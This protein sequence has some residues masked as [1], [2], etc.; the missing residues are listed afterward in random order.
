MPIVTTNQPVKPVQPVQKVNIPYEQP[1]QLT[2]I[3]KPVVQNTEQG[4]ELVM[5]TAQQSALDAQNKPNET[6]GLVQQ[7]VQNLIKNPVG[8]DTK[9]YKQNQLEQFDRN[10]A[11]SMKAFQQ[12]IADV[13]NTGVNAE[14]AYNFAMQGAQ[15][16][17]DLENKLAME[18]AEKERSAML[19]A[20]TAG[21]DVSKT[22]SGLDE[23]AFN[24]LL[25]TRSQYEGERSQTQGFQDNV[26]LTNLGFD[27]ATQLAAQQNGFDLNKLNTQYGQDMAKMI[28]QNDWQGAQNSLARETQIAMQSNDINAQ[29]AVQDK[30]FA[31]EMQKAKATQDWQGGQNA[32]DRAA[33][34]A[35]QN[36]DIQ[37]QKDIQDKQNAFDM[38]KL[39]KTQDWQ[40][41]QNKIE[42]DL[43]L[44]MQANDITATASNI[45]KQI[46]LDKWKQENGQTFT[47]DQAA[48]NRTLETA[49]ATMKISADIFDKALDRELT[50]EV[51][52]G[53]L[54]I[55]EKQLAQT[56]V[57]FADE[58]EFKKFA[59]QSGV[60]E[61][62]AQR[63]WQS[64]ESAFD[65][66]GA[67][68]LKIM[69]IESQTN[70]MNLKAQIDKGMLLTQQDFQ[71]AQNNID[72]K[73][74]LAMQSNDVAAQ[75]ELTLLKGQIDEQAQTAQ[76][77]F[78]DSQ[79]IATQTWQTGEAV[80]SEGAQKAAQYFEWQQKNL[81]QS[82]DIAGQVAL[83]SLKNKFNLNMQTNSMNHEEKMAYLENQFAEA[84]ANNDVNRQKDILSFTYNQDIKKMATEY[85]I[86]T[87]KMQ[88]QGQIQAAL[89]QGDYEHAEAMQKAL[90]TQQISENA[91]DRS[92]QQAQ[93][94]LQA[95]GINLQEVE[96]QYN[97]LEKLVQAG[98]IDKS[99]LTDFVSKVTSSSG[100]TLKAPDPL[101]AQKEAD[102]E[103]KA[104]QVEYARTHPGSID[105]NGNMTAD[106][107]SDFN[108]FVN[109]T[110]YGENPAGTEEAVSEKATN[111]LNDKDAYA[112]LLY[113][114][115][116]KEWSPETSY[117]SGGF[118]GAD[119][120]RFVNAPTNGSIFK[121][122]GK[123]YQV[124][125]DTQMDTKG[126]DSD[127]FTVKDLNDGTTRRIAITGNH[128]GQLSVTG[129]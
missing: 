25:N 95:K 45:Q 15:G 120:R 7:G 22:Q 16:R 50:K 129:F 53:R 13:Q 91:K 107:L 43:K 18:Q 10:R 24:R 36:N 52:S 6:M 122:N 57:Q 60:N 30:Q 12:S 126:E 38:E 17:S 79:R 27:H 75:K 123:A 90:F 59:L 23:T 100:V 62:A 98:N 58:I 78:V 119:K 20:L 40:S 83:E 115:T 42:N 101:E 44:S 113:D 39:N 93:V 111:A 116:V 117:D 77:N 46:D 99:V 125:S 69:E 55:Q 128:N 67:K 61:A 34:I 70:L 66:S 73:L 81:A 96:Q 47:A 8:Y 28:A 76:Q 110:M 104:L 84:K 3:S 4:N 65:R 68:D 56:A 114:P 35:K 97:Q 64:S 94:A 54:S 19:N 51:E 88:V 121:Y 89:N 106:A 37:A 74:K 63:I 26:A 48:M 9:K 87:A 32:L 85:G 108:S 112:K 11:S 41:A 103:F 31:F 5:K 33:A 105:A 86:D 2:P 127:Y 21:Q 14:K 49:L 102:K 72:N 71:A 124:L 80:R 82:N 29:K 92:I 109:K 1:G 118:F